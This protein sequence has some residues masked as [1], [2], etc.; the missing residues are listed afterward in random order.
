MLAKPLATPEPEA[1]LSRA[2]A[3]Q[4]C[5][6]LRELS[7]M[8]SRWFLK[9]FIF[10]IALS[11]VTI[12]AFAGRSTRVGVGPD[13]FIACAF[14][15]SFLLFG[16]ALF[17]MALRLGV[18]LFCL[19]KYSLSYLMYNQLLLAATISLFMTLQDLALII[20]F[21]M[22]MGWFAMLYAYVHQSDPE[23]TNGNQPYFVAKKIAEERMRKRAEAKIKI[24]KGV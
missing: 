10:C 7:K 1:D 23:Y 20:P 2:R 9:T 15:V 12:I 17:C 16:I 19:G 5:A 3:L 21:A 8:Y 13:L 4:R 24:S 22:L 18:V 11:I 6:R 14:G